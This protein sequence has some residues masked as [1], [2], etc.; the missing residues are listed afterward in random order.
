MLIILL[1]L[2]FYFPYMSYNSINISPDFLLLIIIYSSIRLDKS[3]LILI[4]FIIG[5]LRD[6][7]TQYYFLGFISLL[8]TFFGYLMATTKSSKNFNFKYVSILIFTFFYFFID[9]TLQYSESYFFYFK[10]S[11][12]RLVVTISIFFL[13]N[14]IFTKIFKNFEK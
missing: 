13:L 3:K 14:K 11:F 9:Y 12:I 8:T 6:I 2:H 5:L 4:S 10:F 1:L 7:L